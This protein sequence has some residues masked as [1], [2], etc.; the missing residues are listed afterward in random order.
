[1]SE[2]LPPGFRV[3]SP[4]PAGD[5]LPPGF[6][7]VSQTAAPQERQ[8][9]FREGVR[10]FAGAALD[11][12]PVVGPYLRDAGDWLGAQKRSF[13]G[14]GTPEEELQAVQGEMARIEEERPWTSTA[15]SMF[16]AV[17]PLGVA[18]ASRAVAPLLGASGSTGARVLAGA[19]SGAAIGG[20]DAAVRSG[21]DPDAALIG[22]IM[23]GATGGLAGGIG[24]AVANRAGRAAVPSVDALRGAANSAY[25]AA[26]AGGLQVAQ[27]A[28][29]QLV[30][31]IERTVASAGIDPTLHSRAT[32][33]LGRLQGARG[34]APTLQDIELLR[35]V[36][37]AAGKAPGTDEG[38][39]A[40][41][42]VD[43]IDDFL[44][45]LTLQQVVSGNAP[46]TVAALREGRALWSRARKGELI[47]DIMDAAELTGKSTFTQSGAENALRSG[48][49]NLAKNPRKMA[50]FSEPE[51]EAIRQVVT[52]GPI[53]NAMR[54][55]GKYAPTST[56][57]A[58]A[59]IGVGSGVGA[60]LG[61][62]AGA[63]VGGTALPIAGMMGRAGATAATRR[64]ANIV[65]AI[66]R[67]GGT[68]ARA[69]SPTRDA[70]LTALGLYGGRQAAGGL[71][72]LFGVTDPTVRA[73]FGG[74]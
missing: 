24:G 4:S 35:R 55:L 57:P 7:V 42:M 59:G 3:V 9:G 31:D 58:A 15:G 46:A 62:P 60:M 51:Q 38:R 69:E 37:K 32:A 2:P 53:G 5:D 11:G 61:G 26:R 65:D 49:R 73:A 13:L 54:W 20:A 18:G 34:T 30:D 43:R 14:G 56:L 67:A 41:I 21:G 8:S 66:V 23:G 19:G 64:N 6:R 1:M 70:I 22:A 17:A 44:D 47:G 63:A 36:V 28:F 25:G 33:A 72:G 74:P 52:G 29:A 16:G 71:G 39:I 48:F 40:G 12:V 45:G 68:P 50:Q 10:A 27:P